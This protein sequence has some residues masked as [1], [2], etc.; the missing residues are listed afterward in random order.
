MIFQR[1]CNDC[2]IVDKDKSVLLRF[3]A[4]MASIARLNASGLFSGP[5]MSFF[6]LRGHDA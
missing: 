6:Y 4:K 1:S 3:D 2:E 5:K